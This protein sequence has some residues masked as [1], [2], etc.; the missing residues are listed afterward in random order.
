MNLNETEFAKQ[1]ALVGYAS[2]EPSA[3][4]RKALFECAAHRGGIGVDRA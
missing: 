1:N 2:L 4:R 3:P